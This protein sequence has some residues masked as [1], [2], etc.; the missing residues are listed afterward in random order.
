MYLYSGMSTSIRTNPVLKPFVIEELTNL[1]RVY[2]YMK[3]SLINMCSAYISQ[4]LMEKVATFAAPGA[5]T[6]TECRKNFEHI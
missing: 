5:P 6:N 4:N 1:G 3:H 2:F